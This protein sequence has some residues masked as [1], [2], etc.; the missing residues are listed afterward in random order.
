M[1][2]LCVIVERK[3]CCGGLFAND[4]ILIAPGKKSL[5][6]SLNKSHE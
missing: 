4:I 2:P 5:R 3:K 6:K 1:S